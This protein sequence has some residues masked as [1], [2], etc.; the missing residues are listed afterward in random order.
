MAKVIVFQFWDQEYN[1]HL[2]YQAIVAMIIQHCG[3]NASHAKV[4]ESFI[5]DIDYV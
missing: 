5:E 2:T 4:K 3:N 1:E